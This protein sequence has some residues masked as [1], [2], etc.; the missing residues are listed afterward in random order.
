V[1]GQIKE[2]RSFRH[3]SMRGVV[4]ARGEWSLVCTVHNLLKL[5][6]RCL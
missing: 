2:A 5:A 3:F 6:S 1:N 4:K